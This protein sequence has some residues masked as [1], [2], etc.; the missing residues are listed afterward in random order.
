M[1]WSKLY[2]DLILPECWF[3]N[4]QHHSLP[5]NL[6]GFHSFGFEFFPQLFYRH[7]T[8]NRFY[9]ERLGF[10]QLGPLLCY[11]PFCIA[12]ISYQNLNTTNSFLLYPPNHQC[13]LSG[14]LISSNGTWKLQSSLIKI[15][16]LVVESIYSSALSKHV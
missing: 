4:Y 11:N 7:I 3:Q 10:W 15:T 16:I 5:V 12:S 8:V 14:F 2:V 6:H 9:L 1:Y 13:P